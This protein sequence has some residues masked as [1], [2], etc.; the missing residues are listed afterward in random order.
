[1]AGKRQMDHGF[2]DSWYEMDGRTDGRKGPAGR[3]T[4]WGS[5]Q[6]ATYRHRIVSVRNTPH[7][8]TRHTIKL[9]IIMGAWCAD[10]Y[11]LFSLCVG[12]ERLFCTCASEC[13]GIIVTV[14]RFDTDT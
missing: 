4:T 3:W 11:R 1:M 6:A 8:H 12:E 13:L 7:I 5:N 9:I 10:S 14:S 2:M